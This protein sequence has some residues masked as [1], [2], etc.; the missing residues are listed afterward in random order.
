MDSTCTY[1]YLTPD[2]V[3][4]FIKFGFS[5][6]RESNLLKNIHPLH[7]SCPWA[8]PFPEQTFISVYQCS[9][10]SSNSNRDVAPLDEAD[11]EDHVSRSRTK[12]SLRSLE[13]KDQ[14]SEELD[15]M[16][17][18]NV[19]P[20]KKSGKFAC[21]ID[22]NPELND[23]KD[24]NKNIVPS[25]RA[26]NLNTHITDKFKELHKIYEMVFVWLMLV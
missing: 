6:D 11:R 8:K 5:L 4:A 14:D 20:R 3:Y 15:N 9:R 18:Y 2:W 10:D 21:M 7:P 19:S 17:A 16:I 23:S 25:Q 24:N 12:R 22:S 26:K 13:S 1:Y